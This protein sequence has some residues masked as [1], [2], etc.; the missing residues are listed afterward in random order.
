MMSIAS[1]R[2]V[3]RMTDETFSLCSFMTACWISLAMSTPGAWSIGCTPQVFSPASSVGP[4]LAHASGISI[5]PQVRSFFGSHVALPVV[6]PWMGGWPL[7]CL[8]IH[9][10]A[11]FAARVGLTWLQA[12]G[13]CF[14]VKLSVGA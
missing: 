3:L 10:D 11:S 7:I 2:S 13:F 6:T 8:Q 5:D 14:L 12:Y 1:T 4:E 9:S